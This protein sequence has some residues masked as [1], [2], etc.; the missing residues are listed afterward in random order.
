MQ[1]RN[2]IRC[3]RQHLLLAKHCVFWFVEGL[4]PRLQLGN[5]S[6]LANPSTAVFQ[7]TAALPLSLDFTFV[8]SPVSPALLASKS[9][10]EVAREAERVS[11]LQGSLLESKLAEAESAFDARFDATFGGDLEVSGTAFLQNFVLSSLCRQGTLDASP[12]KISEKTLFYE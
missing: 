5:D 10:P 2:S 1:S 3:P 6:P 8:A 9:S 7:L 4:R 11:E 12:L